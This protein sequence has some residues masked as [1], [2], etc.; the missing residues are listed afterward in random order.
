ACGWIGAQQRLGTDFAFWLGNQGLEFTSMGRIWQYLLFV[1]LLFWLL[2][3]GRGLWPALKTPNESRGLIVMVFLSAACIG[4]FYASS[5]MWGQKSHYSMIEYWRWWL[6]HLW[7]EGFFEVFATA[8]IALIFTRLGL[9]RAATANSAIV[10]ETIVFLFGGIL[11]TLHHLY[12]TGSPTSVI[13][14]GAVF[15][16]LE[17]VPL[18][19]VGFEAWNNYKRANSAQW[20]AAYR[21]P[22]YCFIAVGFWN[23]V[24]AGLLGFAINPPIALYYLQGLNMTAAHGHAALFGVYGMLGIGLLL[25]CLRG[26]SPRSLWSDALISKAFWTLNIGLAM[27]VFMSLL[28]AG[29]YQAWASISHGLW[30][31]RS[32]EIIHSSLMTFLVWLRVPGDIVFAVGSVCLAVFCLRLLGREKP[33]LK[34]KTSTA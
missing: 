22:I 28:P 26:M 33:V 2:L 32:P 20:L 34:P 23:T 27:M 13:A 11:G 14:V 15:S 3:M 5:L 25:F 30:Y 24:G 4:G 7:V 6:V 16:A 17:V 8:V 1:G 31:A 19:L 21:W 12:F 9:I 29:I 18:A 10:L